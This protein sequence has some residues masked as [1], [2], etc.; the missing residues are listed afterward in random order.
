MYLQAAT[1]DHI[2]CLLTMSE[3][4]DQNT[5]ETMVDQLLDKWRQKD[6]STELKGLLK[7]CCAPSKCIFW[8]LMYFFID[9]LPFW[10]VEIIYQD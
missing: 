2:R 8:V 1:E 3:D 6:E 10:A 7:F 5:D 9:S 4:S